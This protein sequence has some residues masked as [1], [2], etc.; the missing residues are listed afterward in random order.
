MIKFQKK[1]IL[2]FANKPTYI[3][4]EANDKHNEL[5]VVVAHYAIP[6]NRVFCQ[7]SQALNPNVMRAAFEAASG[8]QGIKFGFNRNPQAPAFTFAV[9]AKTE[10]RGDDTP[11]QELA[12]KIVMAKANSKACAI[13]KRILGAI[14]KYYEKEI[15]FMNNVCDVFN[16]TLNREL[17]YIQKV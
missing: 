16:N 12:D 17:A 10:R 13:A 2:V 11:N 9:K 7:G 15:A 8:F 3:R 5:T 14:V 4:R 6:L 1:P